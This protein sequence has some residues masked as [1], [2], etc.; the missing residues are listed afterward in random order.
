MSSF[1]VLGMDAAQLTDADQQ[2]LISYYDTLASLKIPQKPSI[3]MLTILADEHRS[4]HSAHLVQLIINYIN[5]TIPRNRMPALYLIDS[6]CKN[7]RKE[8][9]TLFSTHIGAVFT[10][11]YDQ[12]DAGTQKQLLHL[13]NTWIKQNVFNN[14]VLEPITKHLRQLGALT[15]SAV[16][17]DKVCSCAFIAYSR[18]S[19]CLHRIDLGVT[20]RVF[21]SALQT[22]FLTA[23]IP[24]SH[25]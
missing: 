14:T 6:I 3:N 12:C 5:N 15:T 18:I 4:A 9:I 13:Y 11:T 19:C 7:L 1:S 8:Y 21:Y 20:L 10:T 22:V 23:Q 17:N 24:R 2:F 16:L 25:D